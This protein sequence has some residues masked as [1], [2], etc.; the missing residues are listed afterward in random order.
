MPNIDGQK[1]IRIFIKHLIHPTWVGW[2]AK[3]WYLTEEGQ[4]L[5]V[6]IEHGDKTNGMFNIFIMK[7]ENKD[8]VILRLLQYAN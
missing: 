2:E 8:L 7:L 5:C 6:Y 3:V 1:L 4:I